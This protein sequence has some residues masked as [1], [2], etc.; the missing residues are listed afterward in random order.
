MPE[1]I[2]R[3]AQNH[4]IE[5]MCDLLEQLYAIEADFSFERE[6]QIQG[7][8]LLL[9]EYSRSRIFVA[10]INQHVIAMCSVQLVISTAEGG[11]SAWLEDVVVDAAHRQTG[12]AIELLASVEQWCRDH[13][14]LRIQLLADEHNDLA[15]KFYMQGQWQ[16]T[17]L[18]AWRK[19][20][21]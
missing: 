3:Q 17:Q 12:V 16:P 20:L 4:D 7:L 6:K 9:Q 13:R 11:L 5:R 10:E 1:V 8:T 2:I 21:S 18:R 19:I 15:Q 14:I